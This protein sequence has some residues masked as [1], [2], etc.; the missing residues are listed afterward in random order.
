MKKPDPRQQ[1]AERKNASKRRKKTATR[2]KAASTSPRKTAARGRPRGSKTQTVKQVHAPKSRCIR[3]GSTDR[4]PYT[5]RRHLDYAG[6]IDGH[7]FNR[8]VWR[9]TTCVRCGQARDDKT[10]ELTSG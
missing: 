2:S 1:A 6:T 8:V 9:R 5:N 10:H 7:P 4:T 3:C